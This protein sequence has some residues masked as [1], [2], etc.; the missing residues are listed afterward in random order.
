MF[1][2]FQKSFLHAPMEGLTTA[3]YRSFLQ[4]NYPQ[5]SILFTD[6]LRSPAQG[7]YPTKHIEQFIGM[8]TLI[9]NHW[10]NRTAVQILTPAHGR[11]SALISSLLSLG[12]TWIDL[13]LGCPSNTVLKHGG[14]SHWLGKPQ[15]LM[16]L[17]KQLREIIPVTFTV[18]MRLGLEHDEDFLELIQNIATTGVDAVTVHARTKTQ[19]Y[20]DKAN[21]KKIKEAS[22]ILTIPIIGNGDVTSKA[23][24]LEYTKDHCHSVM[25]GRGAMSRPWLLEEDAEKNEDLKAVNFLEAIYECMRLSGV[26]EVSAV[27]K[28]KELSKYIL[29]HQPNALVKAEIMHAQCWEDQKRAIRKILS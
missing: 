14:G 15:E 27:K 19:L 1:H 16:T 22:E 25:I 9:S 26:R 3:L 4:K 29:D 11:N 24:A 13:N 2:L 23:V 20:K 8:D 6:F 12:V 17:L 10:R 28:M 21:W 7:D 5:W 18:K